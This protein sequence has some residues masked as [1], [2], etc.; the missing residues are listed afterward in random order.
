MKKSTKLLLVFIPII[1]IAVIIAIALTNNAKTNDDTL[2]TVSSKSEILKLTESKSTSKSERDMLYQL[3]P[4]YLITSILSGHEPSMLL[5]RYRYYD[6]V[7]DMNGSSSYKTED[8]L[9]PIP[10]A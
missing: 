8:A 2:R 5:G 3:G 7:Y 4:L 1:L 6:P 9:M 10:T